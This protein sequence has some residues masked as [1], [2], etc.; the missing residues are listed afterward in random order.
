M[1]NEAFKN[2]LGWIAFT[3][4]IVFIFYFMLQLEPE[5]RIYEVRGADG[6][7]YHTTNVH[8]GTSDVWFTDENG[9]RVVLGGGYSV[10]EK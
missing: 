6:T 4:L 9:N 2:I 5:H 8:Y 3:T 10:I 7:I 1:K